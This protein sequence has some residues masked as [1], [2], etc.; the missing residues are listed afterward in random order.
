M[1]PSNISALRAG[2]NQMINLLASFTRSEMCINFGMRD[3]EKSIHG[4]FFDEPSVRMAV[5]C[6][7]GDE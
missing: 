4:H 3:V 2:S 5:M 6:G 7:A 1:S